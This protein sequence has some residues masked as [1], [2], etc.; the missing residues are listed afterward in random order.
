MSTGFII[1]V[2]IMSFTLF[3]MGGLTFLMYKYDNFSLISGFANRPKEEQEELIKRG[4]PQAVRRLMLYSTLILL[5]ILILSLFRIPW[6][7]E[8]GFGVLLIYTLVGSVYIQKYELEHKRKKAYWVTGSIAG[9]TLALVAG[10]GIWGVW[11]Q[12]LAVEGE[13]V[14]ITGMYGVQF[15]V[16]EIEQVKLLDELPTVELRTNGFALHGVLKRD[17]RLKAYGTAR[18][19]I[20]GQHTPVLYIK[21]K[22]KQIFINHTDQD[23]VYQWYREL[24]KVGASM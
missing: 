14:S 16:N 6:V 4:F 20:R 1:Y 10:L 15:P 21:A 17:F 23:Q 5:A 24:S 3:I 18:L 12:H 19:F 2:I 11:P 13:T 7:I 8:A 22:D 9:V